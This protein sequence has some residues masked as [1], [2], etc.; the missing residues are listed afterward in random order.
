MPHAVTVPAWYHSTIFLSSEIKSALVPYQGLLP[1]GSAKQAASD[2]G[3]EEEE[4][5]GEKKTA[6]ARARVCVLCQKRPFNSIARDECQEEGTHPSTTP[7]AIVVTCASDSN[8]TNRPL[9][10]L[11]DFAFGLAVT[12]C[13]LAVTKCTL[14]VTKCYPCCYQVL[15][16]V[17]KCYPFSHIELGRPSEDNDL[18]P[19]SLPCASLSQSSAPGGCL[20]HHHH[21]H[22]HRRITRQS[23][24]LRLQ[25]F[26][27]SF[28]ASLH[29]RAT[30]GPPC[31][32]HVRATCGPPCEQ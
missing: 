15:P 1:L 7:P 11:V 27:T 16:S 13:T 21:H 17:T 10:Q 3:Q 23:L 22:H 5:E 6:R 2:G 12:K 28:G 4:G 18:R 30:C 32:L 14:A 25:H 19:S 31:E 24:C 26:R 29:V 8:V 9:R 20:H